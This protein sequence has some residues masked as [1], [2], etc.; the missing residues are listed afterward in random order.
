DLS[1]KNFGTPANGAILTYGHNYTVKA[2]ASG[3]G[4]TFGQWVLS[5]P[6]AIV[7]TNA[8]SATINTLTFQMKT[9][10]SVTAKFSNAP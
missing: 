8:T 4:V 7:S 9:N 2:T 6:S 5:D 3:K 1:Y 10:L